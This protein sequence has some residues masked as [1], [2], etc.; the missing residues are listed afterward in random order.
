MKVLAAAKKEHEDNVKQDKADSKD[1]AADK[2]ADDKKDTDDK[3]ADAKPF[4]AHTVKVPWPHALDQAYRIY[5]SAHEDCP[6]RG[7]ALF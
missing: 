7:E 4:E 6:A 2:K 1:K 3:K 5:L